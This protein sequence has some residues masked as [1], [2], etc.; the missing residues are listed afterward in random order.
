MGRFLFVGL[1]T[2]GTWKPMLGL[3]A[4]L[5][6]RGHSATV[7]GSPSMRS[8]TLAAGCSFLALPAEMDELPGTSLE[9]DEF[10]AWA[11]KVT[12]WT[13]AGALAPAVEASAADVL[14][15]DFL[16]FNALSAAEVIRR[17]VASVVHFG[18]TDWGE[19]DTWAPEIDLLNVTRT[20]LGLADLP[21]IGG[22]T[23]LWARPN[24]ALS[25]LPADWL[26]KPVPGNVVTVGPIA[27]ARRSASAAP[28][29]WPAD[30]RRPLVVIS[31]SSTYMHQEELLGR[32]ATAVAEEPVRVLLSLAGSLEPD[33]VQVPD[34]VVVRRWL[35]F[36][37][38]LPHTRLLVTHGGMATTTVALA[39]DVPMLVIPQ[40]RDQHRNADHVS[41]GGYGL[42]LP[43]DSSAGEIRAA[44]RAM[45][46]SD[47]YGRAAATFGASLRDLGGGRIAIEQLEQLLDAGAPV[48]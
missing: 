18:L 33:Q 35:D 23:S 17:P 39:H 45:L 32:V 3:A 12:G 38:V 1:D 8:T 34:S 5:V 24:V 37:D 9:D 10:E 21:R 48:R 2:G 42:S 6:R 46:D 7:L 20:R 16:Q 11:G 44:V 41:N 22:M 14:V 25:L 4:M 43:A 26:P 31:M 13:V 15:I 29:P 28:L 47:A 27:A 30:D 36:D 19:G 40:S